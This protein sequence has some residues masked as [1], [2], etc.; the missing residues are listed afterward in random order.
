M[1]MYRVYNAVR[2]GAKDANRYRLVQGKRHKVP[3]GEWRRVYTGYSRT[4]WCTGWT[5]CGLRVEQ[6]DVKRKV[7]EKI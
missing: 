1:R 5:Q 6:L 4:M 3:G 7:N 2:G